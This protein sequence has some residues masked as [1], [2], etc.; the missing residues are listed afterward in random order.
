MAGGGSGGGMAGGGGGGGG[1]GI[2]GVSGP[3][4]GADAPGDLYGSGGS[5]SASGS[6]CAEDY[7][8][9]GIGGPS[10]NCGDGSGGVGQYPGE[11]AAERADRLGQTLEQ[12]VEGFDEVLADEQREISTVGRNTEGFGGSGGG[13]AGT[14]RVGLGKQASGGGGGGTGGGSSQAGGVVEPSEQRQATVGGLSEEEIKERTPDDIPDLVSEDI[15]AKQLRE[16]AL[17][18]DDPVLRERLWD[19]YRLYNDLN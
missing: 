13:G 14:G 2:R 16:A 15:V 1:G 8:S 9:G 5:G 10:A 7:S 4:R 11:S 18:E 6:E 17:S 19:E 3:V 12:S